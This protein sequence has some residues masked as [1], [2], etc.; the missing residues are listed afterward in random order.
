M[1]KPLTKGGPPILI[2]GSSGAALK[3]AATLGDGWFGHWVNG[4]APEPEINR[5]REALSAAGR[6][7]DASFRIKVSLV[8]SEAPDELADRLTEIDSLGV[9]EVVLIVPVRTKSMAADLELWAAA[10]A[11]SS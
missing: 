9:Q 3:R 4:Q 8:H 1:P 6:K 11:L 10:A 5:L 2:G 7:D